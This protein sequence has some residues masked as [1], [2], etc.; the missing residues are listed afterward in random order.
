VVVAKIEAIFE[1]LK[2]GKSDLTFGLSEIM[3][4]ADPDGIKNAF[5]R[6][7]P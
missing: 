6:M 2:E 5:N 1:Q 3:S 7:N 4:K